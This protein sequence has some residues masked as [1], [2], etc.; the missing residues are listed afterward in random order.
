MERLAEATDPLE[1]LVATVLQLDAAHNL[2]ALN[3]F[4]ASGS[5]HPHTV[6]MAVSALLTQGKVRP[7]FFLA[8]V[9]AN[10]GRVDPF[11]ATAQILGGIVFN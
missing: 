11:V 4:I 1:A 9:L 3:T 6:R 10:S 5:H 7:A 8:V 2:P